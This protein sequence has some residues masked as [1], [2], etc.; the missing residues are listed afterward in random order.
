[1]ENIPE[2]LK[3][4]AGTLIALLATAGGAFGW[5]KLR[6]MRLGR[7]YTEQ[8]RRDAVRDT[9]QT[10]TL[11]AGTKFQDLLF[12]RVEKVEADNKLDRKEFDEKLEKQQKSFVVQLEEQKLFFEKKLESQRLSTEQKIEN[13]QG[14]INSQMVEAG[15][16]DEKIL[17]LEK[18]NDRLRTRIK[19]QDVTIADLRRELDQLKL[20]VDKNHAGDTLRSALDGD[21]DPLK[22][23]LT[24]KHGNDTQGVSK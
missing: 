4:I 22:V 13:L 18:E 8:D 7:Q 24:D 15:R 6:E 23:V 20:L 5:S 17:N 12:K 1:M 9:N 21:G 10:A 2:G 19:G 16:K 3:W 14:T 11:E